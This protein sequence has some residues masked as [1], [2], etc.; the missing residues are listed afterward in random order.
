[1]GRSIVTKELYCRKSG[2]ENKIKLDFSRSHEVY[3]FKMSDSSRRVFRL[4][5][6]SKTTVFWNDQEAVRL[7]IDHE[8]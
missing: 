1:M 8:G 7:K 4:K 5:T 6:K 3:R 2:A